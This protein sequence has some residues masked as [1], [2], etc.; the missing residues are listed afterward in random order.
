VIGLGVRDAPTEARKTQAHPVPTSGGLGFGLAAMLAVLLAT[1]VWPG[2]LSVAGVWVV[3]AGGTAALLLGFLD[4]ARPLPARVKLLLMLAIAIAMAAGGV[5]AD[6]LTPW[7]GVSFELPYIL[8]LAGSVAW[9]VVV[10]NAVNFMD[11]ANGLSMGMALIGALGLGG[12]GLLC[13]RPDIAAAAL[14]LAAALGGFLVWNIPGKLFAGDAGALFAGAMLGGLSLLLVRE[15]PD[16]L[17]APPLVL[18]PYLSDVLLT[19]A[20]RWKHGKKLFAAHRD[21]AYQIALKAGLSHVQ[22]SGIHAVWAINAAAIGVAAATAGPR[23]LLLAFLALLAA[24][25]WVHRRVR[26]SGERAGLVGADQP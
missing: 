2:D 4:D 7:L 11:G 19:L 20:W 18:M 15:R 6:I 24:S 10:M 5:R 22:V 13:G 26:R 16:F 14:A 1:E 23:V 25:V 3:G 21:H 9:L 17:L 8:A 12:L